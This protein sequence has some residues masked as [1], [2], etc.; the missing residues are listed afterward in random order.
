LEHVCDERADGYFGDE[1][2]FAR[3]VQLSSVV[4]LAPVAC[5]TRKEACPMRM[6]QE[7]VR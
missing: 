3:A 5:S 1:E 2:A 7:G 4:H 6:R